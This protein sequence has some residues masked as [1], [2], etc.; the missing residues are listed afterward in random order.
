LGPQPPKEGEE[1]ALKVMEPGRLPYADGE[2]HADQ[3][4]IDE[5]EEDM[6]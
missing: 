1:P 6:I 2:N 3:Y 5:D 4:I